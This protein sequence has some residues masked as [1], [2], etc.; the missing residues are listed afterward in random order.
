MTFNNTGTV[1]ITGEMNIQIVT[2]NGALVEEFTQNMTDLQPSE[3][4]RF[5]GI[6][7]T[8]EAEEGTYTV[9]G[10]VLYDGTSTVPIMLT[11]STVGEGF[12]TGY[13]T[14]PSIA[15]THDGTITPYQTILVNRLYTHPCSGTGGHAESVK[16]W[17]GSETIV[18]AQWE[19]Y[20]GD[21]Q[22][23]T[24]DAPVVLEADKTYYYTI[25]TGSYPQIIHESSKEVA[26]G[27]I[28]CTAFVDLNG[29][30]YDNWIP[31]IK[32]E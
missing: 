4:L 1:N 18:E 14:Y 24:F 12:D 5:S 30:G 16:I 13:G 19:G 20:Q 7:N 8:T 3:A 32:L 26:G 21:W 6:W 28:T 11:V 15:G 10:F 9:L 31:A 23:I 2:E 22:N 29:K 17:R 25:R 27:A